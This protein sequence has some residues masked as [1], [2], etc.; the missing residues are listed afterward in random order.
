L[1]WGEAKLR[2]MGRTLLST[3]VPNLRS[4]GGGGPVSED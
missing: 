2:V 4:F 3:G 1:G